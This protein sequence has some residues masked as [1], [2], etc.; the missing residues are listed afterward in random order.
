FGQKQ[1]DRPSSFGAHAVSMDLHPPA[2]LDQPRD[3]RRLMVGRSR[4]VSKDD[5]RLCVQRVKAAGALR[6][7]WSVGERVARPPSQMQVLLG[8]AG[9]RVATPVGPE[10]AA[11]TKK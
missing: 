1:R 8:A 7:G 3:P 6:G 5:A 9:D 4:C 11:P 2:D 10:K